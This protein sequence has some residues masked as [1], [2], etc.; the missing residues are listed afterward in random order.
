LTIIKEG[1]QDYQDAIIVN[2]KMD[3]EVGLSPV[4]PPVFMPVP[5]GEMD[6][7]VAVPEP[8]AV[9]LEAAEISVELSEEQ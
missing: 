7:I 4:P 2:G 8:L 6:I 1:Y 3:L 9:G 5:S